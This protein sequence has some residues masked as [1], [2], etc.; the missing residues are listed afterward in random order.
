MTT[1]VSTTGR[2]AVDGGLHSVLAALDVLDC[3]TDADELGVTD[4]AR[5]IGVAKSTAHRLLT[6]LCARGMAEKNEE[7]GRYRLGMKLH[8]LGSLALQRNRVHQTALPLLQELHHLTG[9]TVHLGVP[10]GGQV[11]YLERLVS[12]TAAP[13]FARIGRRLPGQCTSSGK[14]MAAFDRRIAAAQ[15]RAGFTPLTTASI[16]SSQGYASS[17]AQTRRQGFAVSI[18]EVALGLASVAAPVLAHDGSAWAAISVVGGSKQLRG[19]LDRP[20]RLVRLAA[21]RLAWALGI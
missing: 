7:T 11:I 8:E 5:R 18:D 12:P 4:I 16:S 6:T 3:F 13:A 15:A 1:E 17:L 2:P 20:A 9:G 19:D 10:D 21:Q 14:A